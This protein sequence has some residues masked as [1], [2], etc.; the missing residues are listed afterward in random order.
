MLVFITIKN[1]ISPICQTNSITKPNV[2][3]IMTFGIGVS[4]QFGAE[5]KHTL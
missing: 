5:I 2:D 4:R 1:C 3:I